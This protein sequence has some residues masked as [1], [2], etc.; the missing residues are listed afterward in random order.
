[1][2][3]YHPESMPATQA[4]ASWAARD[5]TLNCMSLEGM[6]LPPVMQERTLYRCV[7][8]TKRSRPLQLRW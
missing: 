2:A 8:H 1:M 3:C 7:S 4:Q 5:A 6:L